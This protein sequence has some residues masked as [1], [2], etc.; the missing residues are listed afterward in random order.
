MPQLFGT[1]GIRGVANKFPVTPDVGLC[2]GRAM[3]DW[4]GDS[5]FLITGRDTRISGAMLECAIMSGIM[6]FGGNVSSA[7]IIPTPGLA[8]LVRRFDADG[9]IMVSA[10]HNPFE[11][12][13]FKPFVKGG[14]KLSEEQEEQIELIINNLSSPNYK[15]KEEV[16]QVKELEEN[17]LRCYQ[18]FLID[19]IPKELSFKDMKVV[20]DCANGA[21]YKVAPAVFKEI[22]I[23]TYVIHAKPDGKNINKECGA[24]YPES[25]KREVL[26]RKA[27]VGFAFDGDG[28]RLV[29]V[30]SKG[31][32]LTGDQ[33]IAIFSKMLIQTKEL[34]NPV[35]VTT[36]MSNMGL[37]KALKRMGITHIT[38]K[39]GDRNVVKEMKRHDSILGGEESG[40]IIFLNHHTTGDGI[41]SA[42]KLLLAIKILDSPLH[43][44]AAIMEVFPQVL[45]NVTVKKKVEFSEIPEVM[46]IIKEVEN[47]LS[48]KGRLL[49]RYSGTE[50]VCRIMVE[51]EDKDQISKY[52]QQIASVIKE[53]LN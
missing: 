31:N 19:I 10:S 40:H 38:T 43:E 24:V 25:L 34:K 18:K 20:V 48:G 35:V 11:Y 37:S 32:V 28:D 30:D 47:A 51:G 52:A 13:G 36:V 1:D 15:E 44:L 17:P 14:E 9:G 41:L 12:N 27:D 23:D 21:T 53:K 22:G 3:V 7:G 50:P 16:G 5:A 42:L 29:A 49:L 33:L 2:L 26:K 39:V 46:D 4:L 8:Y 6:S 45:V